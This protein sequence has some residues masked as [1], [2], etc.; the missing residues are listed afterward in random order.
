M[1]PPCYWEW[2]DDYEP[3]G[4][5]ISLCGVDL[6][7]ESDEHT[8]MFIDRLPILDDGIYV[9]VHSDGMSFFEHI[10]VFDSEHRERRVDSICSDED[11]IYK[12]QNSDLW[13][14]GTPILLM[15]CNGGLWG[16]VAPAERLAK[17][18]GTQVIAAAGFVGIDAAGHIFVT[19]EEI[20]ELDDI[21]ERDR[22]IQDQFWFT[23]DWD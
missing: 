15:A 16:S 11:V 6:L 1:L 13:E 3:T 17:A 19:S 23:F 22:E 14:P 21:S 2:D 20:E 7:H 4:D 12:I 5:L 10:Y 9:F 18:L 8:R